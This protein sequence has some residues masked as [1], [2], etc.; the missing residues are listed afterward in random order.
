[1]ELSNLGQSRSP[2]RRLL[3]VAGGRPL[4]ILVLLAILLS[5]VLHA[6]PAPWRAL[7][8]Q[9][10]TST[11][12]LIRSPL[13]S[14]EL[15]LFDGYQKLSPRQPK[16]QPVTIVAIDEKS[17]KTLGQWPW[18]RDLLADLINTLGFYQPAA[19]GLDFYMP[20]ADPNSIEKL[21]ARLAPE[22]AQLLDTLNALPSGDF[23]LATA[24]SGT[25]SVLGAAGFE[26]ATYTTSDNLLVAPIKTSGP[27]PL[28]F[29]THYPQVLASLEEFQQAASGQALLSVSGSSGPVRRVAGLMAVNDQLVPSLALEMLRVG[30]GS[31]AIQ[32]K[33]SATGIQT[34]A[35][36][37]LQINTLHNSEIWLHYAP[38][39]TTR[40]RYLSA[41]DL[42]S[43]QFDPAMVENKLVLIGLTGM[44]L[45]DM[46]FSA[47]NEHLP[48]VEI[49]AQ[50]I[51]S[52][53]DGEVLDRP[54]WL[55]W[56]EILLIAAV[57]LLLILYAPRSDT[58]LGARLKHHPLSVLIFIGLFSLALIGLG[59]L[60]F[61]SSDIL[62]SATSVALSSTLVLGIFFV[63]TVLDNLGEAQSRLARLVQNGIAL[64]RVHDRDTLLQMT[65]DG[66][67]EVTH[68]EA[69]LI[70]L[71]DGD[72]RLEI[73]SQ[74]G[75]LSPWEER[76]ELQDELQT[77]GLLGRVFDQ[78][79]V[80]PLRHGDPEL[81]E[82]RWS[83]L[84]TRSGQGVHSLL[85]VP[86]LLSD[87]RVQGGYWY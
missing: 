59:V 19:I 17:L 28:Q 69:S 66:A 56:V 50:L 26:F 3:G 43:G 39:D 53:F 79:K 37:D 67:A 86:M 72:D 16:S 1:M 22:Q 38:L 24:L 51:E 58:W 36:A 15:A 9:S 12:E 76:I 64:A 7:Y 8:P 49:H 47:L 44:G 73:A 60:L 63:N 30:T 85:A 32:V 31:E 48:G 23:Q 45:S 29:V 11:L 34:L 13:R 14:V 82:A 6:L 78:A 35:V 41:V 74:R 83:R 40:H 52:L 62:F 68:C 54:G 4:A 57:G 10:F 77:G 84:Q 18:P 55:P 25:P 75:L 33:S 87:Q 46:R 20:E 21:A 70:L 61:L 42:L 71:K 80:T 65:L 81:A 2:L 27:D 5:E